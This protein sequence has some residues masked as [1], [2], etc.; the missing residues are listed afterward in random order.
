MR[1]GH[2]DD[3]DDDDPRLLSLGE[4]P[5]IDTRSGAVNSETSSVIRRICPYENSRKPNCSAGDKY[6][7][8]V[9]DCNNLVS[10]SVNQ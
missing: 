3:D 5:M 1:D 8:T 7:R 9:G 2:D 4:D 10:Q 6:R